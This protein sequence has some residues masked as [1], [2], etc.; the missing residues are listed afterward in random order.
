MQLEPED[1]IDIVAEENLKVIYKFFQ[2]PSFIRKNPV[3]VYVAPGSPITYYT[4]SREELT[5]LNI[6]FITKR[7]YIPIIV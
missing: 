1:F 4:I 5:G 3:H 7:L 2:K 6:D